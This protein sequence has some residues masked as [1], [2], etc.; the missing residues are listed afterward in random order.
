VST[1]YNT[2]LPVNASDKAARTRRRVPPRQHRFVLVSSQKTHRNLVNATSRGGEGKGLS[3]H[4][5]AP[6]GEA[7]RSF[8]SPLFH[9]TPTTKNGKGIAKNGASPIP[10]HRKVKRVQ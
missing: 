5:A 8:V 9:R 1:L 2:L 4:S 10:I 3:R 7:Y 6:E